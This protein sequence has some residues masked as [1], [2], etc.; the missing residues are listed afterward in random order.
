MEQRY[1]L[2]AKFSQA[3]DLLEAT[4]AT[5]RR[6]VDDNYEMRGLILRWADLS[7][8][9]DTTRK[10]ASAVAEEDQHSQSGESE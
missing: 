1:L 9:H 5:V 4:N 6:L 10:R 3:T 2:E 7:N 8:Q